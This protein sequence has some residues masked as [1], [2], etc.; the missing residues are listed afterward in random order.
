M[1]TFLR[2]LAPLGLLILLSS[3]AGT[4]S[5]PGDGAGSQDEMVATL[6]RGAEADMA[7]Q[8]KAAPPVADKPAESEEDAGEE[9][10]FV[11]RGTGELINTE[12][13]SRR[14]RPVPADGDITFNFEGAGIPE[15]VKVILGDLLQE[16]YVIAPGVG[17]QVTFSTSQP[18]NGEQ[19]MSILEMLL[20]WNNATL[21]F[22]EGRYVVVPTANAV[23]GNLSP[24][25]GRL[26]AGRGYEVRAVPLQYI[27]ATEME[28][29]LQPYAKPGA[30]VR[31]DNRRALIVVAGTRAELQ[32]YLDTIAVF[33]VDWLAGMSVGLFPLEVVEADDLKTE[34][35]ALF[36]EGEDSPLAGVVQILPIERLNALMVV[37]PNATY[38]DQVET[39]IKRL[40][41][42]GN[43][44]G[45]RLF[46][47]DVKNVKATDLA[48]RLNDIFGSSGGS[49][50]SSQSA[51][52]QVA[53]GLPSAEIRSSSGRGLS[54]SSVGNVLRPQSGGINRVGGAPLPQEGAG[55]AAQSTEVAQ[56]PPADA[57]EQGLVLFDAEEVRITAVEENNQLLIKSTPSQYETIKGAIEQLDTVP[58]QVHIEAMIL[59]VTLT[60]A[61]RF[62]VN[63]FLEN[64]IRTA[65]VSNFGEGSTIPEYAGP[66][67]S[68]APTDP[69]DPRAYLRNPNQNRR[70]WG[71]LGAFLRPAGIG[72]LFDGPNAR[73]IVD[74]LDSESQ[75]N[76]LSTPSLL[77]LNNK[78][79]TIN[80]GQQIPINSAFVNTGVT[81]GSSTVVQYRDT[82]ITLTV[83]PRVNPGGLVFMEIQQEDSTPGETP[84]GSTNPPVNQKI[85]QTEVAVQSG[86][87]VLLAGLIKQVDNDSQAGVPV[88]RKV[89]VLGRLLGSSSK[90]VNRSELIVLI[91]PTV[92]ES[93]QRAAELTLE[94]QQRLRG[95]E[96]LLRQKAELEKARDAAREAVQRAK[97]Q[98]EAEAEAAASSQ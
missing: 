3:C 97:A 31:A 75:V 90:S 25:M 11:H 29:L 18:V 33:D 1:I 62:G 47:Y 49:S 76:V 10:G 22:Q 78:Q 88:L 94:Y 67:P 38:L 69:V 79:A 9:A 4:G 7:R 63:W 23:Q 41:R 93:P 64:A 91:T 5:R 98:V 24:R 80:V 95:L 65:D 83:I 44:A 81:T 15:V 27:S 51:A 34:L 58:L 89:P 66:P 46:V 20:S 96:P 37:T 16:N 53:P 74:L 68:M 43:E 21:I 84:E 35:D 85:I 17:G 72:W 73:A 12:A 8:A 87:T 6:M 39:W 59:D 19:A 50:G 56:A 57:G 40:D 42:A 32:N 71:S 30:V 70:G 60:N 26:A 82:G 86:Q 13:A 2:P 77:V 55:E 54:N 61:L 48:D 36:G 28:K 14:P 92:I 45:M 52:G